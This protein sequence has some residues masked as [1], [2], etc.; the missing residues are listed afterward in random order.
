MDKKWSKFLLKL[1]Y[2]IVANCPVSIFI[3][4]IFNA[5][6][7]NVTNV[8]GLMGFQLQ[9]LKLFEND[10]VIRDWVNLQS[11]SD[12]DSLGVGL[13]TNRTNL[14][15]AP[16]GSNNSTDTTATT[17][18]STATPAQGK[19]QSFCVCSVTVG[20]MP[21]DYHEVFFYCNSDLLASKYSL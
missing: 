17:A 14:T 7:L 5:Q 15:T 11:Q 20:F 18:V 12:L 2:F 16:S 21:S 13:T 10:T 6:V 4:F 3:C 9:D 8:R 19:I 1:S